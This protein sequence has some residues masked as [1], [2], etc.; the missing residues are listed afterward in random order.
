MLQ[1]AENN[2]RGVHAAT[3]RAHKSALGQ[4]MTPAPTARFLAGL[5]EP[6]P[7]PVRLLDAGAGLGVL[8]CAALDRWLDEGLPAMDLAV[9][10]HEIDDRLRAHL[11]TTLAGYA[12][13]GVMA[14]AIEAGDYLAHAAAA[15]EAGAPGFTHALLNP[16]YKKIG[17]ASPAR[18]AARRAGLEAVNLYAAFMGLAL[19]QLKDGG[20]LAAIVPRSFCSGPYHKPFRE[21]LLDRAALRKIHLFGS[22]RQAFKDDGVLQE[23]VMV[24]LEKGGQQGDVEV[25]HATDD[26]FEDLV[27][28]V[29]PFAAI[30][31]P[32]DPNRFIHVP[33][34]GPSA[35]SIV[36]PRFSAALSDLRLQVSTGP[37][38]D[39]RARPHLRQ[40]P[41][42]GAVPLIQPQHVAGARAVW[43]APA[44]KKPNAIAA[45]AETALALW[46]AGTYV[47]VRR[48]SSK[49]QR[50]RV[51]ACVVQAK[52]LGDPPCIG[53]ENHLN[54]FHCAKAGLSED[55]AW[56]LFV[57]LN[58]TAIDDRLREFSG[59][60]QVNATDLRHMTYPP[61][62]V[63]EQW[64]RW[65][66]GR[67]QFPQADLDRIV[68]EGTL[69]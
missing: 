56:G 64:G 51:V 57:Y 41:E 31:R 60:T 34:P 59:H 11:E 25:G 27:R 14:V 4:F 20:Q 39:F 63:L 68:G 38:V 8:A 5:F 1:S 28:T 7:G 16:P 67:T 43:P 53:F 30:V 45:H 42:L 55:L 54:V 47:T 13:R 69:P 6:R 12:A 19:A 26:R 22:R 17:A 36:D 48:L 24:L 44:S 33:G 49:E 9:Q 15:L 21:F 58:S 61:Q 10:A 18:A 46:P 52:D 3:A 66:L 35:P 40:G 37:V 2:R 65:A 29:H 62:E 50:R 32:D 23:T